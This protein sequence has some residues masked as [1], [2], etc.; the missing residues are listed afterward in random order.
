VN[1]DEKGGGHEEQLDSKQE[2][3]YRLLAR[4]A[5]GAWGHAGAASFSHESGGAVVS[6]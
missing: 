4:R 3:S 5:S 2:P 1:G 6:Q